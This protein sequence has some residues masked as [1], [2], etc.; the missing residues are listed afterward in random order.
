MSI[1]PSDIRG[2]IAAWRDALEVIP[3]DHPDRLNLAAVA[4]YMPDY[5]DNV[6]LIA[7]KMGRSRD[8]VR[9]RIKELRRIL[10]PLKDY[11]D[12]PEE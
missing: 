12:E 4:G 2:N 3:M 1:N 10:Q 11:Y 8:W 5:G 9:K 6:S 7:R